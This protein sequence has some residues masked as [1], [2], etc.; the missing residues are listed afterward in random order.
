MIWST[1]RARSAPAKW[2]IACSAASL[3]IHPAETRP[4][5]S[6]VAGAHGSHLSNDIA[7]DDPQCCALC[8]RFQL[9]DFHSEPPGIGTRQNPASSS[10]RKNACATGGLASYR[11]RSWEPVPSLPCRSSSTSTSVLRTVSE[12]V[13]V[14]WSTSLRTT[15]SSVTRAFLVYHGPFS[16]LVH[17]DRAFL[18]DSI[19]VCAGAH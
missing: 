3:I 8:L 5:L 7:E 4:P 12:I 16:P 17:F 13:S 11:F 1:S 18:E 19:S 2:L 9:G 10:V 14:R 6:G 15:S